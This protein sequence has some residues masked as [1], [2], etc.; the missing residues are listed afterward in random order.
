VSADNAQTGKGLAWCIGIGVALMLLGG[1]T[2]NDK[3]STTKDGGTYYPTD[4]CEEHKDD[5]WRGE[6]DNDKVKR[7]IHE[8]RGK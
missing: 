6:I 1:L 4:W 2:N 5:Q 8:C 3:K 7:Y